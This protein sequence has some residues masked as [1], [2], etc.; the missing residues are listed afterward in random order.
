MATDDEECDCLAIVT[1]IACGRALGGWGR[2]YVGLLQP[3]VL[4]LVMQK[5]LFV[6]TNHC[7]WAGVLSRPVGSVCR[8]HPGSSY[9]H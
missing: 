8:D 5:Q 6:A 9:G 3:H 7:G 4:D 1:S 2:G